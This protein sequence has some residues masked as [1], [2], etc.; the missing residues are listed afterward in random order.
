MFHHTA[1]ATS[2][3]NDVNYMCYGSPDAPLA[4]LLLDRSGRV[5]VMA[6]GA[7]NTNGKG[8]PFTVTRGTVPKDS[9]N[10]YAV[11]IEAANNGV[12]EPWPRPQ[13]DAYFALSLML[14]E[15]LGLQPTDICE[16]NVWA[17]DRKIDPA[18]ADA[19]QGPWQPRR[20]TSSGT[21]HQQ[22]VIDELWQRAGA[23]PP[24]PDPLPPTEDEMTVIYA[25]HHYANTFSETGVALS[26]EAYNAMVAAGAIVVVSEDHEQH[27]E[28]L[29][30]LSGLDRSALIRK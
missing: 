23:A 8:G 24:G 29:L 3:E 17:P 9:M 28:S 7:T 4:N 1:S 26:P 10:T 14:S 20:S 12:G 5:W 2:P 6:G 11:S 21:W 30:H 19:V 18:V 27:I 25:F 15:R 22:D 13:I 16:H